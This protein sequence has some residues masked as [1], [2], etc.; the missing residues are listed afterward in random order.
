MGKHTCRQI[1]I[2]KKVKVEIDFRFHFERPDTSMYAVCDRDIGTIKNVVIRASL[3][4]TKIDK[5][6]DGEGTVFN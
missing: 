4:W 6:D 1:A 3:K 5:C 2:A